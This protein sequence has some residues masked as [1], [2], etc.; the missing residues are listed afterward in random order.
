MKNKTVQCICEGAVFVALSM[1]LSYLKIPIGVTF[2]GFGGSIDLVMIPLVVFS[3][4]WGLS[5]GLGA[6]LIFGT[7]KFFFA[8]GTAI[9]WQSMLL[10]YSVAYMMV[11]LAG[12]LKRKKW[13]LTLGAAVGCAGRFMIHFIS[14]ITIYKIMAPSEILGLST[15]SPSIF[16]LLYNGSYMLPNTVLAISICALIQKPLAGL[17]GGTSAEKSRN[18]THDTDAMRH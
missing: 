6:G 10:D 3:V 14:G 16:S 13:G 12:F 11:G 18:A 1:A 17:L 2:G 4:K 7:L 9:N 5:W 8:G 15:A